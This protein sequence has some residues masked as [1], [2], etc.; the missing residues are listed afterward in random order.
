MELE[1]ATG[2]SLSNQKVIEKEINNCEEI[3]QFSHSNQEA[4]VN[5]DQDDKNQDDYFH[6]Y[7][8]GEFNYSNIILTLCG[9]VV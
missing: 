4:T 9:V 8:E 3:I 5:E 6:L 7:I 1:E 2:T